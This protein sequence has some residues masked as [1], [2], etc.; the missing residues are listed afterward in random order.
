MSLKERGKYANADVYVVM[1]F[2]FLRVRKNEQ[3]VAL[4]QI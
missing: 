3:R 2:S 4:I 1:T